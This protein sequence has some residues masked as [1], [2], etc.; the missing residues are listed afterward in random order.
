MLGERG[1]DCPIPFVLGHECG[2]EIVE[3]GSD[4]KGLRAGDIVAVEPGYP[5]GKCE[6]CRDGRYNLCL[7]MHY[8]TAARKG[9]PPVTH[10]C[11]SEYICWPA[12]WVYKMPQGLDTIDACLTEPLAVGFYAAIK[13]GAHFTQTAMVL[14]AGTIGLVTLLAL[15]SLG[16]TDIIISD[17]VQ[18]RLDLAMELGASHAIRADKVSVADEVKRFTNKRRADIV[19]ETAGTIATTQQTID[20]VARGGRVVLVGMTPQTV[21]PYDTG[22]LL[23]NEVELTGILRYRHCYPPAIK[24][25]AEGCQ[26][27]K[28]LTGTYPLNQINDAF[29]KAITDK[30]NSLKLMIEM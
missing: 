10:G 1:W 28:L 13:A 5:C 4:V 26:A 20:V 17:V 30:S 16:V 27:R 24:A 18:S 29:N 25:L 21:I 22:K 7:D 3:M 6:Y 12:Q 8:M 11:Y 19:F 14:G 23:W 2:G 15:K 9:N